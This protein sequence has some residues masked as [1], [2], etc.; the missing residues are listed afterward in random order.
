MASLGDIELKN[1]VVQ[2]GQFAQMVN[3]AFMELLGRPASQE[4][5]N[6]HLAYASRTN[7]TVDNLLGGLKSNLQAAPEAQNR[8][9]RLAASQAQQEGAAAT[10]TAFKQRAPLRASM[11]GEL[12]DVISQQL[13]A[14]KSA[15]SQGLAQRGLL[16]SGG[17]GAGL[18]RLGQTAQEA[19]ARGGRAIES[20]SFADALQAG[21]SL[22]DFQRQLFLGQLGEQRGIRAEQRQQEFARSMV[23]EP[24]DFEKFMEY[25]LKGAGTAGS[26]MGGGRKG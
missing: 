21:R 2:S 16:D 22:E 3:S 11:F 6:A 15:L 13:G 8:A 20:E 24:T 5:I 17:L 23:K 19:A 18:T 14:G 7:E 9:A 26:I 25:L 1:R 4:E 10:E 12:Q